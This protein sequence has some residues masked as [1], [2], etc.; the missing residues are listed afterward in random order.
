MGL[1]RDPTAYSNSPV[2][3]QIRRLVWYQICFLD[4]RTSE[5]T[6]PR[7]QIR[8]ED[9]DT[10]RPLNIDDIDL[11]RAQYGDTSIDVSQDRKH[12]TDMTIT[13]MRLDCYQM[14]RF[15]ANERPKLDQ[16]R[17]D[18]KSEVTITTLLR[19]LQDFTAAM[20]K[21]YL[22]MLN[23]SEPSHILATKIYGILSNKMYISLLQKY[24][25]NS[26][27]K[28][29]ERLRQVTLSTATLVLEH[30]MEIETEPA[31][32]RW[33]WYV[34]A[35]HQHHCAVLLVSEM[36]VEKMEPAMEQRIWRCLDYSFDLS[37]E[38]SNVEKSRSV[39]EDLVER[40]KLY[41]DMKRVRAPNNMPQALP[42]VHTQGR[43]DHGQSGKERF[44]HWQSGAA[45]NSINGSSV[46][47]QPSPSNQPQ[48]QQP[49]PSLAHGMNT[50]PGAMPTVDWGTFDMPAASLQQPYSFGDPVTMD[51]MGGI[52]PGAGQHT[53]SDTS[54]PMYAGTTSSGSDA[55]ALNDV[56]W[57][58]FVFKHDD[59]A[60]TEQNDIEKMFG[61]AEMGAG[62]MLI[63][64]FTFPQFSATNLHWS[65]QSGMQ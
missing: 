24:L 12:F 22:P 23:K 1:H 47:Q 25:T 50:F 55:D 49:G 54:P 40:T 6:G 35:L 52:V 7:P 53:G 3:I 60:N 10:Q 13:R 43:Q 14:F 31:L 26:R 38:M 57:V 41:I 34:G 4:L 63:P 58:S 5:A 62:N 44:G 39:L 42:R 11:D 8:L 20:E 56:D 15:L 46:M 64:P 21:T 65:A 18:G 16:K 59:I 61:G 9:Y 45:F 28:M 36:W 48:N 29:P 17:A 33:A 27:K 2:G 51:N 30:G 32:S 19:R 37:A